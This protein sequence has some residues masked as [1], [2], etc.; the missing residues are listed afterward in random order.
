MSLFKKI[1]IVGIGLIGGSL[2]L[3]IKR[4]SVAKEVIGV[5]RSQNTLKEALRRKVVDIATKDLNILKD[6]D[7]VILATPVETIKKLSPLVCKIIKKDSILTDVGSTKRE[8]V[9]KLES[10]FNNYIGS[11]PLAGSQ[12]RGVNFADAEIFKNSL[13]ILTPTKNTPSWVLLKTKKF[14]Q[15]IGAKVDFLSPSLHDHILA[16]TSH[17]PH[18]VAFT[19]CELLPSKYLKYCASSFKDMTRVAL[20]SPQLWHDIFISNRKEILSCLDK[21]KERILYLE[22]LLS[23][24]KDKEILIFLKKSQKK[25]KKLL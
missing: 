20:S 4:Y 17:L 10:L 5:S 7:M 18:L 11:H 19:F 15:A 24:N 21:F 8:I 16:Y 14:W 2:G 25:R 23:Q 22:N 13:C 12:N 3:A 1:G 6:A 9:L